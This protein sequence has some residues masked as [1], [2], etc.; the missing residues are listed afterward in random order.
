MTTPRNKTGI[1]EPIDDMTLV[2]PARG[3]ISPEQRDTVLARRHRQVARLYLRGFPQGEIAQKLG[4]HA[5]TVSQDLAKIRQ[6][7]LESAKLDMDA[8][9]AKELAKLDALEMEY[10]RAWERSKGEHTKRT[11]S[12]VEGTAKGE[13]AEGVPVTVTETVE[14]TSGDP[15][16]LA[17]IESCMQR[18]AKMLGLDAPKLLDV[19][20]TPLKVVGGV[21]MDAV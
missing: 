10:W 19:G 7:W 9:K 13:K 3:S 4:V 12:Y 1:D 16:F 17:G 14:Q 5:S 18:R 6:Y 11:R 15:R 21:D 2:L 20:V 8:I